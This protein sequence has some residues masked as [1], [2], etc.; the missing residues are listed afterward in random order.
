MFMKFKPVCQ[1][2]AIFVLDLIE[3]YTQLEK[4]FHQFLNINTHKGIF[5][6]ITL[7]FV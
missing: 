4:N 1:I 2:V 3:V 7:Y 6:Y 5:Q